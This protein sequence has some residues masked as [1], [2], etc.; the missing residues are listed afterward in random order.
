MNIISKF[1][2]I[3]AGAIPHAKAAT[4]SVTASPALSP[5]TNK[6]HGQTMPSW[7]SGVLSVSGTLDTSHLGQS[8]A[9]LKRQALEALVDVLRSLSVWGTAAS[10]STSKSRDDVVPPPSARSQ[11]GDRRENSLSALGSTEALRIQTPEP[12]DDPGRF[13]SAK[14]RKTTLL[15]GIKKFNYKPKK[16]THFSI[17]SS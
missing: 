6:T 14:Q 17:C 10:V 2:T 3:T 13:E 9:Q 7:N 12:F 8:D 1:G 15:E 5:T 4:D 11:T 16:V